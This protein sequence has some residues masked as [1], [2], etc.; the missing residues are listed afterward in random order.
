[1][2]PGWQ[3]IVPELA[4]QLYRRR[5]SV[6]RHPGTGRKECRQDAAHEK[7]IATDRKAD[8]RPVLASFRQLWI[9]VAVA[10]NRNAGRACPARGKIL[11]ALN[12]HDRGHDI[13]PFIL[14]HL[15]S[16][17][18]RGCACLASSS[19]KTIS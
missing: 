3:I 2:Q 9:L 16:N 1:L 6:S 14:P 17:L 4:A 11:G 5:E 8:G 12:R 7:G 19:K 18:I 10:S 15:L 13:A